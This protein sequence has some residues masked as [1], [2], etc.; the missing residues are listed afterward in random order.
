[1]D[2][3]VEDSGRLIITS[4]G[5]KPI[6]AFQKQFVEETTPDGDTIELEKYVSIPIDSF[7]FGVGNSYMDQIANIG[8]GK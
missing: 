4:K 6:A 2:M 7:D 3:K 8:K 5:G 1:M